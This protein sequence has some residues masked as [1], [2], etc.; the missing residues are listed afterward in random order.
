MLDTKISDV[1]DVILFVFR[2]TLLT[3]IEHVSLMPN[4][5]VGLLRN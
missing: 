2:I 5:R 1:F 3:I 4:F